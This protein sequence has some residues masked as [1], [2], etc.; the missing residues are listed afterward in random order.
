MFFIHANINYGWSVCK[1]FGW[2]QYGVEN[3]KIKSLCHAWVREIKNHTVENFH[4]GQKKIAIADIKILP[5][6]LKKVL[7]YFWII[8]LVRTLACLA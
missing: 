3:I 5:F 2:K 4:T 8:I 6:T 7:Q 1:H